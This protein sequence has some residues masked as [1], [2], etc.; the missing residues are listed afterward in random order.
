M[1]ALLQQV[2]MLNL[3]VPFLSQI[4]ILCTDEQVDSFKFSTNN[5][6]VL[7]K[8]T[9]LSP[10]DT[11]EMITYFFVHLISNSCHVAASV[12]NIQEP[13]V[14]LLDRRKKFRLSREDV[15]RW[16]LDIEEGGKCDV[17]S[18]YYEFFKLFEKI[19]KNLGVEVL[20]TKRIEEGRALI[21][22]MAEHTKDFQ[23]AIEA[24]VVTDSLSRNEVKQWIVLV[25]AKMTLLLDDLYKI[26]RI[27][28]I[29]FD[30]YCLYDEYLV[31]QKI[32]K[33]DDTY[34]VKKKEMH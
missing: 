1:I 17:I 14:V 6:L 28:R 32:D 23:K 34:I 25:D 26:D 5:F 30:R 8:E 33:K 18:L 3:R 22:I 10:L 24:L 4:A 12:S 21:A 7:I 13:F 11:D 9:H 27:I 16:K 20:P 15:T 29:M 31:E 19:N 2:N